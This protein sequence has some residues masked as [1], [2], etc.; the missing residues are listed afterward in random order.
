MLDIMV[1]D[2]PEQRQKIEKMRFT[3]MYVINER[4][5]DYLMFDGAE[6]EKKVSNEYFTISEDDLFDDLTVLCT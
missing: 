6:F 2:S 1:N 4:N 5:R 3:T